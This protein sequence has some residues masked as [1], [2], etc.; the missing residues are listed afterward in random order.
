MTA[1]PPDASDDCAHPAAALLDFHVN[2]SLEGEEGAMVAA[3]VAECAVCA[4]DVRELRELSTA[5]EAYGPA[6]ATGLSRG[7]RLWAPLATAAA[8]IVVGAVAYRMV[9]PGA[10]APRGPAVPAGGDVSEGGGG[11]VPDGAPAGVTVLDL[12]VGE[13]RGPGAKTPHKDLGPGVTTLRLTLFP[14]PEQD[15]LR[16]VVGPGDKELIG[17]TP[18]SPLDAGRATFDIPAS[19]FQASGSYKVILRSP[20]A[21]DGAD[22][23]TYPFEVTVPANRE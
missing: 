15:L 4:R 23:F 16:S 7:R 10:V 22:R 2:G 3:H 6:A 21:P 14:P 20:A 11:P 5:I 13:L 9:R 18:L 12:G 1:L 19:R 17:E 8:V